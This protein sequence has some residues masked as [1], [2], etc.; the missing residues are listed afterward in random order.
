MP[1]TIHN[2][3][4]EW[5]E[6]HQWEGARSRIYNKQDERVVTEN[7]IIGKKEGAEN[8]ALRYYEV[9][10]Q[11]S[12]RKERHAH[13]HGIIILHGQANAEINDVVYPVK[14]GDVI[15][16]APNDLHVFRNTGDGSF[17]FCCIIPAKR[18]VG[19]EIVW[20]EGDFF[21]RESPA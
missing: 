11:H 20:A 13:D 12:T 1:S 15:Y 5:G 6:N 16:V 19:G 18:E 14:Q 7:W 9:A 10:P 17:G 3:I 8:F 2:F 21:D 4:G